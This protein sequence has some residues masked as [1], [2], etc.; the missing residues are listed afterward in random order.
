MPQNC[1]SEKNKKAKGVCLAKFSHEERCYSFCDE[2]GTGKQSAFLVEWSASLERVFCFVLRVNQGSKTSHELRSR[3]L[4]LECPNSI[5]NLVATADVHSPS[6]GAV[7]DSF[8]HKTSI[9][10]LLTIYRTILM[11]LFWR[12]WSWIN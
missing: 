6:F 8:T 5:K 4:F 1:V 10:I 11:T 2:N 9:V 12:I 3:K 7:I